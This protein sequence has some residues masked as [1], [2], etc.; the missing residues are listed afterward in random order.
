MFFRKIIRRCTGFS[1]AGLAMV[2]FSS[3]MVGAEK[4]KE[5]LKTISVTRVEVKPVESQEGVVGVAKVMLNECIVVRE[6]KVV[7]MDSRTILRFPEYV[8]KKG[9]V[10]PQIKFLTEE[11]RNAV[12][13]AIETGKPSGDKFN[14]V[15]F[16]ITDWFRLRGA[17]KRKVNAEVTFNNVVAVSCGIMEGKRGPWIAWPS[18]PPEKGG[19]SWVKQVYIY[20]EKVRKAVENLLLTKYQAML[21]E[22]GEEW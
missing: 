18:R 22:E 20:D 8:S 16:K 14:K 19:G 9:I 6:I 17:G 10:Y 12:L 2:L 13:E 11:A 15:S 1:V 4:G 5:A 21:Q 7:K 3:A